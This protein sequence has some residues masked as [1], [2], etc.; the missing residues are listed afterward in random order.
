[1]TTT[2]GSS[3]RRHG[4]GLCLSGGGYRAALFH[5]GALR[6]LAELGVLSQVR[7]IS[8]VSGGA[9]IANLLADPRLV[10]PEPPAET[11]ELPGENAEPSD[12]TAVP[13][14]AGEVHDPEG[15]GSGHQPRLQD[16]RVQGFEELVAAPLAELTQRNI[17]TP[18]LL[19]RL[20]PW[21]WPMPDG[22]TRALADRFADAVPW[23]ST[24]WRDIGIG[25]PTVVTGATEIAYGVDWIFAGPSVEH[26]HGRV[27]DYR[28]GYAAPPSD[29]RV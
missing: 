20:L 15:A 25:G 10:W 29:L 12:G 5:L 24:P 2:T 9:I 13:S 14:V 1:M 27:G 17:R 28:V 11:A 26:P 3:P 23:W 8:A 19:T 16:G 22:A 7:T 6:R 21:R 4:V 18:A